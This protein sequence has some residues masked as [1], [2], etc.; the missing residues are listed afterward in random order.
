MPLPQLPKKPKAGAANELGVNHCETVLGVFTALTQLGRMARP[1]V[2]VDIPGENTN[3]LSMT[4]I[5]E[6]VQ[7]PSM[8]PT[9][10]VRLRR[11]GR[12]QTYPDV[13]TCRRC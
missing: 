6:N 1:L 4:V 3:P 10:P 8:V 7:W 11:N 2:E 5:P 9:K 12:F 13:K